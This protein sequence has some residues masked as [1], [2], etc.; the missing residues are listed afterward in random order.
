MKPSATTHCIL[1][2]LFVANRMEKVTQETDPAILE[3]KFQP[4][5]K[6][7]LQLKY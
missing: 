6:P 2:I 5:L 3:P 4:L 1:I 7:Y